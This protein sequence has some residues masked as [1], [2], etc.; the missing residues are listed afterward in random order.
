MAPR[1]YPG[2]TNAKIDN[3]QDWHAGSDATKGPE[4]YRISSEADKEEQ[5]ATAPPAS[6]P[7]SRTP[8][9]GPLANAD[10]LQAVQETQRLVKQ[11]HATQERDK[12]Q[13]MEGQ[14]EIQRS[15]E[16]TLKKERQERRA[17]IK[18]LQAQVTTLQ[19]ALRKEQQEREQMHKRM[20]EEHTRARQ[21]LQQDHEAL[22]TKIEERFAKLK[23]QQHTRREQDRS[24]VE[25][26]IKAQEDRIVVSLDP[27]REQITQLQSPHP[28]DIDSG[29]LKEARTVA[30]DLASLVQA[31]R[32]TRDTPA[33][34]QRAES[35][36][37]ALKALQ[38]EMAAVKELKVTVP[39]PTTSNAVPN[40]TQALE[41]EQVNR[42]LVLKGWDPTLTAAQR[43]AKTQ[44]ALRT[45]K[46]NQPLLNGREIRVYTR[47]TRA[48]NDAPITIIE[49]SDVLTKHT[50][51]NTLAAIQ[52]EG[53]K[54]GAAVTV[55]HALTKATLAKDGTFRRAV[56]L[57]AIKAQEEGG[58]MWR[59]WR[60]REIWIDEEVVALEVDGVLEAAGEW[61]EEL[62]ETARTPP[63]PKGGRTGKGDGKEGKTGA[64]TNAGGEKG[65]KQSHGG[66]AGGGKGSHGGKGGTGKGRGSGNSP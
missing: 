35:H 54:N 56:R 63:A 18:A 41:Q 27:I 47:M 13:I 11:I 49:S 66:K 8:N 48:G 51:H 59:D 37:K 5:E 16:A 4:R 10:V 46:V 57:A 43:H 20:H 36:E 64:G 26:E 28:T 38:V 15:L 40:F 50:L 65:G 62:V 21:K 17:A 32:T 25:T 22:I 61:A 55:E 6:A 34:Q 24:H 14:A 19:E 30:K 3:E 9:P 23:H 12:A 58:V 44:T 2:R 42:Q 7:P 39:P 60:K 29:A 45:A 33:Q 1:G 53:G 31:A 52:L